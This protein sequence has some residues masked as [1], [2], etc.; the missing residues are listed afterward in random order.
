MQSKKQ[1]LKTRTVTSKKHQM[2]QT[3]DSAEWWVA[4]GRLGLDRDDFSLTVFAATPGDAADYVCY[5]SFNQD[6]KL[7]HALPLEEPEEVLLTVI[8]RSVTIPN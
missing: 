5:A 4:N 8:G 1:I 7:Y 2:F 6:T 3:S